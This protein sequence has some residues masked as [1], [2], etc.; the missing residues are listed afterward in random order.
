M[1]LTSLA[2]WLVYSVGVCASPA[3]PLAGVLVYVVVYHLNPD[4]QWWGETVRDLGLRTSLIVAAAIG[5][6]IVL[7]RPR[8][9]RGGQFPVPIKLGLALAVLACGSLIWGV[10]TSERSL[11]VLEKLVKVLVF[12][13]I[14]IRCV[15]RPEHYHLLLLA[16]AVGLIYIGY[17]ALG[18]V[19]LY[20]S[21]RLTMGLGGSDFQDAGDLCVHLVISLPLLGALFFSARTWIG[22]GLALVAGALTV[23]T[24]ILT[25]T[26]SGLIALIAMVAVASLR[27]P[28]RYR[29]KG[30]AAI[31]LG[32]LLAAQLADPGWWERMASTARYQ[33]DA[34]ATARIDFWRAA[35]DM[36][37][38]HPLGVGIGNFEKTVMSYVPG[39]TIPR[40][41]H[42]TYLECLAELGVPG[43]ALLVLVLLST[44][45]RIG[46]VRRAASDPS[47]DA[48]ISVWRFR[49]RFHLGWHAM[50]VQVA[51][52]GYLVAGMFL[53][54]FVSENLWLLIGMAVCLSNV[55]TVMA[56]DATRSAPNADWAPDRE[57][58]R[59]AA[60][61]PSFAHPV[62]GG[63]SPL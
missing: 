23:N 11:L 24:A 9:P 14:L 33:E 21:G 53:T 32:G 51:L 42:N 37:G 46:R 49:A 40:S 10:G 31:V 50:A 3:Y 43:F 52:V 48:Q 4:A 60:S 2:F 28:R 13:L 30:L 26:R 36:A 12:V 8:L 27:L 25:R 6:G 41:A 19:G 15:N 1:S 18:G 57:A 29:A 62:E 34:S 61:M 5:L 56:A 22:R 55:R 59:P 54:R 45:L 39:L 47:F 16:W 38:D 35:L 63:A 17:E 58:A 44:L 20:D 7:R